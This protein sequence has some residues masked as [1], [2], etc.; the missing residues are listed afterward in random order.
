MKNPLDK[1]ILKVERNRQKIEVVFNEDGSFYDTAF[2]IMQHPA[3]QC[4]VPCE[5]CLINGKIRLEYDISQYHTAEAAVRYEPETY[6]A[7]AIGIA[8]NMIE[9]EDIGFLTIDNFCLKPETI[10]LDNDNRRAYMVYIPLKTGC[11]VSGQEELQSFLRQ[12]LLELLQINERLL[13]SPTGK[14]IQSLLDNFKTIAELESGLQSYIGTALPKAYVEKQEVRNNEENEKREKQPQQENQEGT[15][16]D[17]KK[18]FGLV[19]K[20]K[21][22]TWKLVG[23]YTSYEFIIPQKETLIG[24]DCGRKGFIVD[25]SRAVS[26]IQC[27]VKAKKGSFFIKDC[28][29]TNGTF[30]N[31]VRISSDQWCEI[32][33]Q[34]EIRMADVEF[35]LIYE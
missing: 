29:S 15:A 9:I 26:S 8:K 28:S 12:A 24:R 5:Q 18:L 32:T 22:I 17:K 31:E 35:R 34:A 16:K 3:V 27:K 23:K 25:S 7:I 20:Q 4:L 30:V 10:M 11:S 19:R 2:Q 6:F 1:E 14:E 13:V 21:E 33:E